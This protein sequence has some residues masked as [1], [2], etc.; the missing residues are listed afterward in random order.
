MTFLEDEKKRISH[1]FHKLMLSGFL[2]FYFIQ[3]QSN[4]TSHKVIWGK[5]L[6]A[7]P[8][9]IINPI[10]IVGIIILTLYINHH[11]FWVKEQGK[12]VFIL[13]KYDM[14][15]LSKKEM[16]SSKIKIIINNQVTLL[17]I[18]TILY[19]VALLMNS[20]FE[21]NIM[22]N[23]WELLQMILLSISL[24]MIVLI[25]NLLQDRKTKGEI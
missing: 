5:G 21:I 18:A 16:Y 14:I 23:I 10:L 2:F 20:Y 4:I 22:K 12:N 6:E 15:P 11:L 17:V 3:V 19:I 1:N 13:R 7:K 9:S 8:I 25:I 24:I